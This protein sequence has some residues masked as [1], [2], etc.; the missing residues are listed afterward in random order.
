MYQTILIGTNTFYSNWLESIKK[1]KKY[2]II[3]I[4]FSDS[5][6]LKK[7]IA[8]KKIKYIL[9]LSDK[10]YTKIMSYNFKDITILYPN[11]ET[12]ELLDNKLLFTKLF[13]NNFNEF[14]PTVYYLDN[15]KIKDIEYPVISKPIYSTNGKNMKIYKNESEFSQCKD[16]TIVQKF[17]A[18]PYEYAA[19]ILCI[20]GN[21]KTWKIIRF[22]FDKFHIKTSN[23]PNNYETVTDIDIKIFEKL[24]K[25]LKYTGGTCINFKYNTTTKKIDIFELNPRFG[26]S[27]FTNNFIY[28]LLCIN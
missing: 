24:M 16:K 27:A 6:L 23:F 5:E 17:V 10:D 26:G 20:N 15:K 28:E 11:K 12:H 21:I 25:N 4:D 18:D 22:K 9:P 1:I 19:Y 7:T 14:L 13:M 2:N 3:L 8:E